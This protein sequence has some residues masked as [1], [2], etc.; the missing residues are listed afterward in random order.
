MGA[1]A[2]VVAASSGAAGLRMSPHGSRFTQPS[3]LA[4]RPVRRSVGL[5]DLRGLDNLQGLTSVDMCELVSGGSV[6]TRA[7]AILEVSG[8]EQ[9]Q[10]IDSLLSLTE[11]GPR[12]MHEIRDNDALPSSQRDRLRQHLMNLSGRTVR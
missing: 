3:E 12:G 2:G 8:N 6:C 5:E 7:P 11:F 9:L 4:R 1:G 10:S